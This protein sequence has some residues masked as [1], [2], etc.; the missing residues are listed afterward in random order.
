MNSMILVAVVLVIIALVVLWMWHKNSSIRNFN[1]RVGPLSVG[2]TSFPIAIYDLVG[3][4]MKISLTSDNGV[5][6]S[7]PV[8]TIGNTPIVKILNVGSI[9]VVLT[10]GTP[11]SRAVTPANAPQVHT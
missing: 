8:L 6:Q 1:F 11:S 9:P 3:T 10:I 4:K 2:Q 7:L 5:L